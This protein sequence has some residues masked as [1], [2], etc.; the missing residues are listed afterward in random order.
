MSN[1]KPVDVSF[2][3]PRILSAIDNERFRVRATRW[4]GETYEVD[5]GYGAFYAT[6]AVKKGEVTAQTLSDLTER[7]DLLRKVIA[8]YKVPNRY[9]S[10]SAAFASGTMPNPK[11]CACHV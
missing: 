8:N 6:L 4:I 7:A 2:V 11:A 1:A 5:F 9:G 10:V 3:D